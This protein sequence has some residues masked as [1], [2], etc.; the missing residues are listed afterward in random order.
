M[1]IAL[2]YDLTFTE[3][4]AGWLTCATHMRLRG[5]KIY[6]VT[7]R[8][9]EEASGMSAM[10]NAACD[11]ILFTGRKAK[12]P[13]MAERGIHVNVWIDDS[14]HWILGDARA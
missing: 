4:P 9:P 8:Y 12:Q 6:G 1:I 13:F 14:P 3:D 2:D 11:E 7:M 10:F 5:H